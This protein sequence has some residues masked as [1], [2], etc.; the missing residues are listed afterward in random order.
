MVGEVF[1]GVKFQS[2]GKLH[3]FTPTLVQDTILEA[4]PKY[5]RS[6]GSSGQCARSQTLLWSPWNNVRL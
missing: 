4:W 3:G 1:T 5:W 2:L 6:E